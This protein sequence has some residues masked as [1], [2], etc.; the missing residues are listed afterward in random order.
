MSEWLRIFFARPVPNGER[1]LTLALS[2][3]VLCF[4]LWLIV[5]L[6]RGRNP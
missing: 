3:L 2:V 1:D 4:F 6:F 5:K